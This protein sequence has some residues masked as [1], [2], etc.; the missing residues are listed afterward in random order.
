M[1]IHKLCRWVHSLAWSTVVG[2]RLQ[3]VARDQLEGGAAG[4][5]LLRQFLQ[6]MFFSDIAVAAM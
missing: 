6:T 2:G 5:G 4:L 3:R 1:L